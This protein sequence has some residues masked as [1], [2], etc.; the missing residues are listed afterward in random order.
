MRCGSGSQ[1]TR[2]R[3]IPGAGGLPL[4][5]GMLSLSIRAGLLLARLLIIG[6]IESNPGP[7]TPANSR[8]RVTSQQ[9]PPSVS[10][11][12]D[13]SPAA[14][15]N[16]PRQPQTTTT[17]MSC[18]KAMCDKNRSIRC[19]ICQS[20]IHL[21]C[22]KT[23]NYLEGPGWR[24]QEPPVYL[25]QLFNTPSFNFTCHGCVGQ[26][27][28]NTQSTDVIT[29]MRSIEHKLDVLTFTMGG[30][31]ADPDSETVPQ[32]TAKADVIA[33]PVWH[34]IERKQTERSHADDMK[35]TIVVTGAPYDDTRRQIDRH[36]DDTAFARDL[37]HQL[38]VDPGKIQRVFRFR[39][40]EDSD[41]PPI[42]TITFM[43]TATRDEALLETSC[44]RN[45]DFRE[46]RVRPS[47]PQATRDN[48]DV[49]YYG[50]SHSVSNTDKVARCVYNARKELYEL[51]YLFF[52]TSRNIDR[53]DWSTTVEYTDADYSAWKAAVTGKRTR[54][55]AS[56][57]VNN[58]RSRRGSQTERHQ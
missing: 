8:E 20:V 48:R 21:I 32:T 9:R 38:G 10:A 16:Q 36:R 12:I 13:P 34:H 22:L 33:N 45:A 42:M 50:A 49:L 58:S 18:N 55:G 43:T 53:V 46:I 52:D 39:K 44:L 5:H 41:R 47:L 6:G 14:L 31:I 51:R 26:T 17:C 11:S 40:R 57:P 30:S 19:V 1:S 2:W 7:V 29:T 28:D 15:P 56:S 24:S 37:V 23:A 3:P 54:A 4:S 27:D 35:R 25:G